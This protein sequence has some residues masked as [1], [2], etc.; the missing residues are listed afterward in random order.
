M[1]RSFLPATWATGNAGDLY[2]KAGNL[3]IS[4]NGS[5]ALAPPTHPLRAKSATW[6]ST[7][8]P[9]PC[10]RWRHSA[11]RLDR[12][13]LT[14]AHFSRDSS[15]KVNTR[16]LRLDD[17][18]ITASSTGNVPAAAIQ[19]QANDLRLTNDSHIT[20]AAAQADAGPI[21]ISGDRLWLT[22]SLITTSVTGQTGHGGDITLT[23]NYLILDGGFI[24]ANTAAQGARG[25]DIRID[26]RALIA[27]E[28]Q[29][30][31]GGATRQTFLTGSGRNII[32]AAAEGGE[33]GTISVTSPDLD[34]T[35]ALTPL[36]SP[37]SD[38][39]ELFTNLCR[40]LNET[41][42]S[43]LVERGHGGLPPAPAA[44]TAISFTPERLDRLQTASPGALE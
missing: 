23:P 41:G 1:G 42:T 28:G 12:H 7:P 44:P 25:G 4:G 40:T 9:S 11:S 43:S 5:G 26:T 14:H 33:Q 38:P 18:I 24:Q 21:T 19:I 31:I 17:G 13:S 2:M 39:D 27:R 10:P 29:L 6:L 37:F 20:T 22:D 34:I 8:T 16:Q 36:A 3:L 32:Q 35:A 30:D 15:L